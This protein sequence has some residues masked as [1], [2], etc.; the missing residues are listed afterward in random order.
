MPLQLLGVASRF[1]L[2]CVTDAVQEISL[3]ET[4]IRVVGGL[5]SA[6]DLSGEKV[7]L[8]R[9]QELVELMLPAM[10]KDDDPTAGA[11]LDCRVVRSH[12][13]IPVPACTHYS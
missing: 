8:D 12:L 5:L 10:G 1:H 13:N 4:N 2:T 9:A 11:H 6:F 7:F 3:F